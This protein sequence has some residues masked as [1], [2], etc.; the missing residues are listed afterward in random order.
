MTGWERNAHGSQY[1]FTPDGQRV[2]VI[3]ATEAVRPIS[4]VFNWTGGVAK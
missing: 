1:V 3:N 2:L 4:L